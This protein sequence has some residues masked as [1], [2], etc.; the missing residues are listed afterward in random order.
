VTLLSASVVPR[1]LACPTSAVL[2][3]REYRTAWADRGQD[4]HADR[5]VSAD[6]R[7][8]AK[9]PPE[10][11]GLIGPNDRLLAEHVFGYDVATGAARHLGPIPREQYA[12]AGLAPFEI[13]GKPDLTI[14]GTDHVVIVDYKGF[15]EVEPSESNKQLATYALMVARALG[16]DEV[17]V[18]IVYEFRRPSIAV[19][20]ALDLD[21]H[22]ERLKQLYGDVAR[23]RL[24]PGRY[25]ATGPHCKYCPA[26]LDC[27]RQKALAIDAETGLLA[28]RVE[29]TFPF[30][31]DDEAAWALDLLAELKRLAS[32]IHAG[33]EVRAKARPIPLA[34]GNAWGPREK[35]GNERLDGNVM[36]AVMT[37]KH[38]PK[39]ADL[40]A[41]RTATKKALREALEYAGADMSLDAA[42][43]VVLEAVRARG[44]VKSGTKTVIEEY[45]PGPRLVEEAPIQ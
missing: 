9:L 24:D 40:A 38:G 5:E 39:L 32:R 17:T 6:L 8:L 29:E 43:E 28:L 12:S 4:R 20:E 27:P 25:L 19:L 33:L 3:Q 31:D 10:V 7:D 22:A 1:V 21:A 23:A 13:P 26:F 2:P 16:L 37:E 36:H 18:V 30:A 15:E 11:A 35:R 34:N 45:E 42:A 41:P 44:G 14:V